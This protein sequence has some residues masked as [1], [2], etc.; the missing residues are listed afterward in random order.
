MNNKLPEEYSEVIT[1]IEGMGTE[2]LTL[3][4]LQKEIQG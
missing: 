1:V 2:I 4:I 3:C